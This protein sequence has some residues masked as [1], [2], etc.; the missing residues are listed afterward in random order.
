MIARV[1]LNCTTATHVPFVGGFH[2]DYTGG[3]K[4]TTY[5]FYLN[6]NNGGTKFETG[7]FINSVENRLVVFDGMTP[8]SGV[9]ATDTKGRFVLNMNVVTPI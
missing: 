4:F 8:H 3:N 2:T 9:T 7:E 1:K 6:T 5:V